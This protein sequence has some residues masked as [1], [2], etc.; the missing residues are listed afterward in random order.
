MFESRTTCGVCVVSRGNQCKLLTNTRTTYSAN[1][2]CRIER[3]VE[4][5][6]LRVRE[7]NREMKALQAAK[8]HLTL[9]EELVNRLKTGHYGEMYNISEDF[10]RMVELAESDEEEDD[11]EDADDERLYCFCQKRSYGDVRS[12]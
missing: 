8:I 4:T 2:S 7:A 1:D 10:D 12:N 9:E 6:K 5:K 3:T 11:E